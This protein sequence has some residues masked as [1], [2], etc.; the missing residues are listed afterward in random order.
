MGS[1][2]LMLVRR[3]LS[4]FSVSSFPRAKTA[5][6]G[7]VLPFTQATSFGDATAAHP[8]IISRCVSRVVD[9]VNRLGSLCD[10]ILCLG[11]D[12]A[13]HGSLSAGSPSCELAECR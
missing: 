10:K 11:I 13:D 6:G 3:K 9:E 2:H 4:F 8:N 12:Y 5:L 1:P 7:I